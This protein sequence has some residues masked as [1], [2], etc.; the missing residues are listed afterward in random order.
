MG[1]GGCET[2][3]FGLSVL[4]WACFVHGTHMHTHTHARGHHNVWRFN[5]PSSLTHVCQNTRTPSASQDTSSHGRLLAP[6]SAFDARVSW[7]G[8]PRARA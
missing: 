2:L 7:A 4:T 3:G 1:Q 5:P 8:L 6:R